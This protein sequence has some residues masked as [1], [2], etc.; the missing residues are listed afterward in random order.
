MFR[1]RSLVL[2]L[3]LA[4]T[5]LMRSDTPVEAACKSEVACN[6][7]D[8]ACVETPAGQDPVASLGGFQD[9]SA[10]LGRCGT[11]TCDGGMSQC[12]CGPPPKFAPCP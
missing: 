9:W 7:L 6:Y 4:A 11:K 2:G 8:P 1:S 12:A 10:D 5:L 3:A